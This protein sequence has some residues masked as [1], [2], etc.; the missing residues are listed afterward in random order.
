MYVYNT[1]ACM[2]VYVCVEE[3]GRRAGQGV[4]VETFRLGFRNDRR[5]GLSGNNIC[6]ACT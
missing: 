1:R 4:S 3:E 2:C 6:T 5:A